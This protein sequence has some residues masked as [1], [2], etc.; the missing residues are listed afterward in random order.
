MDPLCDPLTASPVQTGGEFNMEPYLSGQFGFMDDPDRQFGN[1]SV[2]TLTLTRSDSPEPLLTLFSTL[3][4]SQPQSASPI[5]LN[6]G[7]EV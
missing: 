1:I 7:L 6:H 2:W 3:E 5:S 4:Q